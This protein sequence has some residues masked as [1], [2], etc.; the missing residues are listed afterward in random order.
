MSNTA[1]IDRD[2]DRL[3]PLDT[4]INENAGRTSIWRRGSPHLTGPGAM[5]KWLKRHEA[6]L[7]EL[8]AVMRIGIAW[9]I[10]EPKFEPIMFSIL[11]EESRK[12]AKV[13]K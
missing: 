5:G 4:W 3:V 10:I 2:P 8:G 12:A 11:S 9:R 6:R 1:L 7:T 13:A